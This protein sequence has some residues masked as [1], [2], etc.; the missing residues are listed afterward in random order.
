MYRHVIA[1]ASGRRKRP[2]RAGRPSRRCGLL[3][4]SRKTR[5]RSTACKR[6][7][8]YTT[9]ASADHSAAETAGQ[10]SCVASAH[11]APPSM[12][13]YFHFRPLRPPL[14]VRVTE[15]AAAHTRRFLMLLADFVCHRKSQ[16]KNIST[17]QFKRYKRYKSSN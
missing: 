3:R 10:S 11:P 6:V 4:G 5:T 14:I 15:T 7:R 9:V 2:R 8:R 13:S 1:S 17:K 16:C 12:T